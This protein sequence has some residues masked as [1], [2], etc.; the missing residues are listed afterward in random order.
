RRNRI[1][2][3]AGQQGRK[4]SRVPTGV[5][6]GP[7]KSRGNAAKQAREFHPPEAKRDWTMRMECLLVRKIRFWHSFD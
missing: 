6:T 2:A 1:S 5:G 7:D 4:S 3:G